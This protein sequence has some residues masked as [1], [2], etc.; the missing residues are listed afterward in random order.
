MG[1]HSSS[2]TVAAVVLWVLII[3]I[4]II[5]IVFVA[6]ECSKDKTNVEV[7]KFGQGKK[8]PVAKRTKKSQTNAGKIPKEYE[9]PFAEANAYDMNFPVQE[10]RG[11]SRYPQNEPIDPTPMAHKNSGNGGYDDPFCEEEDAHGYNLNV[12]HLMPAS[13]R[14]DQSA[15]GA[16]SEDQAQWTAFAPSKTAFDN[17]I[18]TAGSSRLAVNTRSAQARQIG[19]PNLVKDA[20]QGGGGAPVPIGSDAVLFNDSD[21]RQTLIYNSTGKYPNIQD[22]WC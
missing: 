18:T 4:V 14:N 5:I 1:H 9:V 11:G 19:L 7:V 21:F 8:S 3:I 15:C 13:W 2:N 20:V 12:N 22:Q 10:Q 17:Y 16:E 6:C